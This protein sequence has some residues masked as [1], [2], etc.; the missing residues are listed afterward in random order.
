M[1]IAFKDARLNRTFLEGKDYA[2]LGNSI[3]RAFLQKVQILVDVDSEDEL[4]AIKS[5]H[6][7]KLAG[8]R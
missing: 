2:R 8:D 1:N 5:L 6:F 3:F 4:Y 7:E